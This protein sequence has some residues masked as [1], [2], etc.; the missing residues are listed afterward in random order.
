MRIPRRRRLSRKQSEA[1][2]AGLPVRDDL[3]RLLSDARHFGESRELPG[4]A[5]ALA[6]FRSWAAAETA[7]EDR[8]LPVRTFMFNRA[9]LAKIVVATT[10]TVAVGGV[11]VAATTGQLPGTSRVGL[12]GSNSSSSTSGTHKADPDRTRDGDHDT[13]GQPGHPEFKGQVGLCIAWTIHK[14][15]PTRTW[16][17]RPSDTRPHPSHS[18]PTPKHTASGTVG[19]IKPFAKRD[20]F[21]FPPFDALIKAAG[22]ANK[23]DAY[24]ANLLKNLPKPTGTRTFPN[25]P[26]VTPSGTAW[27]TGKPG[28]PGQQSNNPH[29]PNRPIISNP[30]A[31][32][33]G[34]Y[35]GGPV[36]S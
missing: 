20:K 21:K 12:T 17:P 30:I 7:P 1:L 13:F 8:S 36:N 34:R 10:A 26:F 4:E 29:P 31:A 25:H 14:N 11:A 18:W 23:V 27:P 32:R 3:A 2:L 6:A 24:C 9:L 15:Q 16:A 22:G 19:A 33:S 5:A 35:T 28:K